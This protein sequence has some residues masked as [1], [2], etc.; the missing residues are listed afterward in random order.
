MIDWLQRNLITI[1]LIILMIVICGFFS[2]VH[3]VGF[4]CITP[5]LHTDNI[6]YCPGIC[7]CNRTL[8]KCQVP[9]CDDLDYWH[10]WGIRYFKWR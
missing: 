9:V 2:D 8:E 6:T 10:W 1:G 5:E 7:E 4:A 3:S